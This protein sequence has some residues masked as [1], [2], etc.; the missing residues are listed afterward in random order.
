MFSLGGEITLR[1]SKSSVSVNS[2]SYQ[3]SPPRGRHAKLS[4]TIRSTESFNEADHTPRDKFRLRRRAQYVESEGE[5]TAS[6]GRR[7][8]KGEESPEEKSSAHT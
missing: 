6:E 3:M 4:S 1:R 8:T 2:H 5:D 7:Q